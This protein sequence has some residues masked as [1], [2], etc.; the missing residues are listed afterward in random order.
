M[1]HY[2]FI[3]AILLICSCKEKQVEIVHPDGSKE[4]YSI[5][6][7]SL[8][9]GAYLSYDDKGQLSEKAD[10]KNGKLHGHREVW[11]DN[12]LLA[13]E[14]YKNGAFDGAYVEYHAN[15]KSAF[16]G[17]YID[18]KLQ[19]IGKGYYTN[20]VLKS[21]T[22]FVDNEENGP[23]KDYHENGKLAWQGTYRNGEEFGE[24]KKYNKDG[25]HVRTLDCDERAICTTTWTVE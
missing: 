14:T 17:N 24:L 20:G 23:F 8:K 11:A 18:G 1:R 13:K 15:G 6:K 7:D 12:V 10:Y 9:H 22:T 16:E 3:F 25:K 4:V 2:L 5:D 21:E 19:G